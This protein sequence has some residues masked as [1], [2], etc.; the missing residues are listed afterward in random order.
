MSTAIV[1]LSKKIQNVR[2]ILEENSEQIFE[3]LP[4]HVTPD[5][6]I[7]TCLSSLRVNPKLLE[8]TQA[9]LFAAITEAAT[10]GLETDGVL[11]HAYL[12]PYGN[13]VQLLPGYKGLIDLCRRSGNISTIYAH[14][15]RPKDF[16]DYELGLHLKLVHKP[17]REP[18]DGK[19]THTYAVCHLRDG[20][21]QFEV[22]TFQ[23]IE[24]HKKR[25]AKGWNRSDS[26]WNTNPE[27]M[28]KKTV[29]RRLVKM[30]PVSAEV[31]RLVARDEVIEAEV[32]ERVDD[33]RAV[34]SSHL[35]DVLAEQ[36]QLEHASEDSGVPMGKLQEAFAT[37]ETEANVNAVFEEACSYEPAPDQG[38]QIEALR[39]EAM[40]RVCGGKSKP[41][42]KE[43]D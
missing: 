9:S 17:S 16:F 12:V 39:V 28:H 35:N 7:R 3:A 29:L 40:A 10:L 6:M 13:E 24:D 21:E 38:K 43:I 32:S 2:A 8:C 36:P 20:G 22:M 34:R 30:L 11:G 42:Q 18:H 27:S 41:K 5:R 33:R 4:R 1:P 23:E 25:Y 19:F 15:V 37:A 31:Q 26:P 14:V